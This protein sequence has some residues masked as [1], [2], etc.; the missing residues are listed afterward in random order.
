M[1]GTEEQQ[2]KMLESIETLN[3][4]IE[5]FGQSFGEGMEKL[6]EHADDMLKKINEIEKEV[7]KLINLPGFLKQFFDDMA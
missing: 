7:H 4:N 3:E 5:S 2:R 6:D 1:F